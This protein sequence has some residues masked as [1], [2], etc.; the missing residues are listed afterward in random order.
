MRIIHSPVNFR[1]PRLCCLEIIHVE[2]RCQDG[3]ICRYPQHTNASV[4]GLKMCTSPF[5]VTSAHAHINT[6][7][8]ESEDAIT[9][10]NQT[11]TDIK[12]YWSFAHLTYLPTASI[13]LKASEICPDMAMSTSKLPRSSSVSENRFFQKSHRSML[14]GGFPS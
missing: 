2:L 5:S 3:P 1:L 7:F 8:I 10:N 12:L 14:R 4:R 11:D 6:E 13:L 9:R